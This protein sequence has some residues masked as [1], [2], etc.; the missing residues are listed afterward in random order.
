MTLSGGMGP[1]NNIEN[2]LLVLTSANLMQ[3]VVDTLDLGVSYF[4]KGRFINNEVYPPKGVRFAFAEP[5][6][7]AYGLD[8]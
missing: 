2:D 5:M 6:E 1:S 8:I 3:R 4:S 7:A